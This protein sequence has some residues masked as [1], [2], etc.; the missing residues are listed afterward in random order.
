[1]HAEHQQRVDKRTWPAEKNTEPCKNWDQALCLWSGSTAS[2]A[3][4]YQRTN[5]KEVSNSE[6]SH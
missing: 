2:Q 5:P 1:M 6:T 3:L 4:D